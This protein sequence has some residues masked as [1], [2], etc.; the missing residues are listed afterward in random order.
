[1]WKLHWLQPACGLCCNITDALFW[2]REIRSVPMGPTTEL[3]NKAVFRVSVPRICTHSAEWL[4]GTSVQP[5]EKHH[6]CKV[7][8]QKFR[9]CSTA[10]AMFLLFLIVQFW[11]IQGPTQC[12]ETQKQTVLRVSV[13]QA[14]AV[15]LGAAL[16]RFWWSWWVPSSL[17]CSQILYSVEA[18]SAHIWV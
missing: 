6:L 13:L 14:Q 18:W 7:H 8:W 5:E 16:C 12:L 17:G 2:C 3:W 1:M 15:I 10:S 9:Q 4:N 11:I